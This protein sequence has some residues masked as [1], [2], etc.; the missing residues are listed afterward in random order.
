MIDL[1]IDHFGKYM[2]KD[3]LLQMTCTTYS[4][5]RNIEMK[6]SVWIF[7][8]QAHRYCSHDV[9]PIARRTNIQASRTCAHTDVES[10]V[11]L[12]LRVQL[13]PDTKHNIKSIRSLDSL[14]QCT[15]KPS[16]YFA[17]VSYVFCSGVLLTVH[18]HSDEI[19]GKS[20]D[21]LLHLLL[22][23]LCSRFMLWKK[24]NKIS[25]K[26]WNDPQCSRSQPHSGHF[27]LCMWA[28]TCCWCCIHKWKDTVVSIDIQIYTELLSFGIAILEFISC[29]R[30][31]QSQ[32][33]T[34]T[35]WTNLRRRQVLSV[36]F[37][38]FSFCQK[39][40]LFS[41]QA[42][43]GDTG[44]QWCVAQMWKTLEAMFK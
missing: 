2:Q 33:W 16:V 12:D 21:S 10:Q 30:A 11:I 37:R 15:R 35:F 23:V 40:E 38:T 34:D 3:V 25:C 19:N 7:S 43:H 32:S 9:V 24:K 1:C 39:I 4:L 13:I 28:C 29:L 17:V 27:A 14:F 22:L 41:G 5:A 42:F 26:T 6:F 20:Y 31:I 8:T 18:V 44:F 36:L